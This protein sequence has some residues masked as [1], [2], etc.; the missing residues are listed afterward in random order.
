VPVGSV[1]EKIRS[2]FPVSATLTSEAPDALPTSTTYEEGVPAPG[3]HVTEMVFP[4]KE[5]ARPVGAPT[6]PVSVEPTIKVAS[7]EA[8]L[9]PAGVRDL[10]RTK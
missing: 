8:A 4:V 2:R 10:T 1:I 6:H 3:C 5:P 9:F 7:L